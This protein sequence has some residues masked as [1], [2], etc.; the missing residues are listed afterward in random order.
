MENMI[1]MTAASILSSEM[2]SIA[3]ER[4]TPEPICQ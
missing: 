2:Q 4:N 1:E 3:V